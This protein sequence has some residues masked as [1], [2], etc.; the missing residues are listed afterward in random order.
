MFILK[1]TNGQVIGTGEYYKSENARD[2]GI[3]SV[4]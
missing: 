4:K 1:A 2:N 3:D